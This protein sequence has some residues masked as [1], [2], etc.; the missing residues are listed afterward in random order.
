[1]PLFDGTNFGHALMMAAARKFRFKP[2]RQN[3][4]RR[5]RWDEARAKRKYVGV[6]VFSA[7]ARGSSIIT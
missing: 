5:V 6:V 4:T 3:L 2:H 1:M 7:V